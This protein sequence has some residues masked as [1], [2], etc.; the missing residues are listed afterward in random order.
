[1]KKVLLAVALAAVAGVSLAQAA[2]RPTSSERGRILAA[3]KLDFDQFD[4]KT[5]AFTGRVAFGSGQPR[6]STADRH[7]AR[8]PDS[9]LE[10]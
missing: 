5:R 10:C 4:Q 8:C 3:I 7:W 6:V 1:M 2:R 9:D